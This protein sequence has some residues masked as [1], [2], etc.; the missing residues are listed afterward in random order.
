MFGTDND[1][2]RYNKEYCRVSVEF[3]K[4]IILYTTI[5]CFKLHELI[6]FQLG[7]ILLSYMYIHVH[8]SKDCMHMK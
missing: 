5:F 6:V 8:V 3:I 1:N 7:V 2:I 4:T